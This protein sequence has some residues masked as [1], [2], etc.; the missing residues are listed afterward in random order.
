MS[1]SCGYFFDSHFYPQSLANLIMQL[2]TH[3]RQRSV[4]KHYGDTH[5]KNSGRH[6]TVHQSQSDLSITSI[7]LE[8]LLQILITLT[9][10]F[11][12]ACSAAIFLCWDRFVYSSA[13]FFPTEF[14]D[15][16]T[17]LQQWRF[18]RLNR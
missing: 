4:A 16:K 6:K 12:C 9:C 5:Y 11:T 18:L 17:R 13:R 3:A 15:V 7:S 2:C 10:T 14:G 1:I 8:I